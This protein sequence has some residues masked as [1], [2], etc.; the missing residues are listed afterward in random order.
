M[1]LYAP[2]LLLSGAAPLVPATNCSAASSLCY[3]CCYILLSFSC[4]LPFQASF[5][6]Q[7]QLPT[8][9]EV[10]EAQKQSISPSS[11]EEEEEPMDEG[12][13]SWDSEEEEEKE[14]V[15]EA[16]LAIGEEYLAIPQMYLLSCTY[17]YL[18]EARSCKIFHERLFLEPGPNCE[19]NRTSRRQPLLS[20]N[21]HVS[22]AFYRKWNS[23][24]CKT[25]GF[26]RWIHS[27]HRHTGKGPSDETTPP[28]HAQDKH[29]LLCGPPEVSCVC[30]CACA[31]M[32]YTCVVCVCGHCVPLSCCFCIHC[33]STKW[34]PWQHS[35]TP[36]T[37]NCRSWTR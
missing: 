2:V 27:A 22:S 34:V 24:S 31:R 12:P 23:S 18:V 20:D 17:Q 7:K 30:V 13:A 32:V 36:F 9:T 8:V 6:T 35:S 10:S 11:A 1:L 25:C 37:V 5:V 14:G 19:L 15:T 4:L 33:R 29:Y 28:D 16:E 26:C 3:V 21:F